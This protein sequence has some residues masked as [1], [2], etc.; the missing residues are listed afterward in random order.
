MPK[1]S[2]FLRLNTLA[3]GSLGTVPE[4]DVQRYG[5]YD[6]L[7]YGHWIF[8][9][10]S[11]A[12]MTAKGQSGKV[13][14]PQGADPVFTPDYLELNMLEGNALLTD[15]IDTDGAT[16]TWAAVVQL[17]DPGFFILLGTLENG[18]DG[19]GLF[20]TGSPRKL[21]TTVRGTSVAITNSIAN[22]P[23]FADD[24]WYFI[25]M[26]RD[27]AGAT[28]TVHQL[29]GSGAVVSTTALAG[30]TYNENAGETVALGHAYYDNGTP[31][32]TDVPMKVREFITYDRA[33]G[34]DELLK[35]YAWRKAVLEADGIVV[36]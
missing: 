13:L 6:P 16:D 25:A 30:V 19:G 3:N 8:K 18:A 10:T 35:L 1:A 23:D 11:D 24:A 4:A 2:L 5:E 20:A 22:A 7:A 32:G 17:S 12:V 21:Y 29:L 27:F 31:G 36:V 9:G 34:A 28:K 33:L 14:T 15:L 26:S